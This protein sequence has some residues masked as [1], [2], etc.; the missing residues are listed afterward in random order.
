LGQDTGAAQS[1]LI[2]LWAELKNKIKPIADEDLT[3]TMQDFEAK[4]GLG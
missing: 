2:D 3:R 4:S 1:D